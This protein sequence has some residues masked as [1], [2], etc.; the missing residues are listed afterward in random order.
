[1]RLWDARTGEPLTAPLT[2][3]REAQFDDQQVADALAVGDTLLVRRTV[4]T[5]QYERWS[6]APDARPVAEL[7]DLAE[8]LAGRRRDAAGNL[9]PIP[10]DDLF[11]LR[12]RLA[13]RCPEQFGAPVPSADAVLTRRH[14]PRV[15]QLADLLA[16]PKPGRVPRDHLAA[17]LGGLQ[18]PDAVP[19]LMAALRDTDASVRREAAGALGSFNPP[20]AETVR[21]LVRTLAEDKDDRVRATRRGPARAGGRHHEGRVAPALKEDPRRQ[22]ARRWPTP[23]APRRPTPTCWRRCGRRPATDQPWGVRVEAAMTVAVLAPDDKDSVGVLSAALAT[24]HVSRAAQYLNDLGPRAAP[25]AAA[26]AKVVEKGRFETTYINETWYAVHALAKIGPA[27][28]PAMPALLAKL[29]NDRQLPGWYDSKTNYVLVHENLVAYALARV[30]PDA[31]PELRK[32][33]QTDK[34]AHR[35]RGAVLA[36]GF[37]GPPAKAAVADLETEAKKL[38]A[39]EEKTQDE[40]WLATALEKALGRIRD[41]NAIPVEKME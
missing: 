7:R 16:D 17:I 3:Q 10:A 15:K 18:D 22:C 37:L 23:C 28:K 38:A 35:R 30:G 32:V 13:S 6:L 2:D 5:S 36:L 1:M 24:D 19:S 27:A 4:H 41:A 31:V 33:F 14:D 9:Q 11:A 20:A 21:A 39:K 40:Q 12:K 26:L 8:A 29:A 34:D 25:A